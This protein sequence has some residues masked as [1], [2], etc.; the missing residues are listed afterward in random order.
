MKE[1]AVKFGLGLIAGT[2][3]LGALSGCFVTVTP[4]RRVVTPKPHPHPKPK[5]IVTPR[6]HPHGKPKV[7]VTRPPKP[8]PPKVV[9]PKKPHP[10]AVWVSGSWNWDGR[11]W[12]W[13]KGH[14]KNLPP[15]HLKKPHKGR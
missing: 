15:G 8:A 2:M 11:K 7:V 14:W 9:K 12:V 6:P 3:A 10:H 13:Q 1:K 5:V 4:R